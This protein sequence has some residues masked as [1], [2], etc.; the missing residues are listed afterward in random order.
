[1]GATRS[2]GVR[3]RESSALARWSVLCAVVV[4]HFGIYRGPGVDVAGY[5]SSR[6]ALESWHD[7]VEFLRAHGGARSSGLDF[8]RG[9]LVEGWAYSG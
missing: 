4:L 7:P 6:E 3:A 1:M 2:L 9:G 5:V 8:V